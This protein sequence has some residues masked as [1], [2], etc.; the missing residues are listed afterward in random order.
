MPFSIDVSTHPKYGGSLRVKMTRAGAVVLENQ[1]LKSRFSNNGRLIVDGNKI[2]YPYCK[3]VDPIAVQIE[4]QRQAYLNLNIDG[5][6]ITRA[7][8]LPDHLQAEKRLTRANNSKMRALIMGMS[9]ALHYGV[10]NPWLV[11]LTISFPPAIDEKTAKKLL[12]IWLTRCN[13]DG[14]IHQYFWRMEYQKNGTAHFHVLVPHQVNVVHANRYMRASLLTLARRGKINLTTHQAKKYNGVDIAKDRPFGKDGKI[15]KS[16][17]R[18]KVT[19]FALKQK[20]GALVIY[21]S[22]YIT[23]KDQLCQGRQWG[24]SRQ[25]GS[26]FTSVNLTK[27]ELNK[28]LEQTTLYQKTPLIKTESF[29]FLGVEKGKAADFINWQLGCLNYFVLRMYFEIDAGGNF[30]RR[31]D[32]PY[33]INWTQGPEVEGL[34][35]PFT[36]NEN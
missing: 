21:M 28:I 15:D 24:C 26:F 20:A 17:K 14:L 6:P 22:K 19:N 7:S 27:L 1:S 30:R 32:Q 34:G 31:A 5:V 33:F 29:Y 18:G 13:K 23:K 36:I 12:N 35:F 4:K 3:P 9:D 25:W 2:R 10:L 16:A 8:T 11:F